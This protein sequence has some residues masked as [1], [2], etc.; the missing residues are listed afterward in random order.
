MCF[1]ITRNSYYTAP[2]PPV[3]FTAPTNV[4]GL[5]VTNIPIGPPNVVARVIA[6]TEA[7]Q[8]G[9]PGAYFK[10]LPTDVVD[11]INNVPTPR[12]PW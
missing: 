9:V 1:F 11:I 8:N 2:S 7:G 4:T 3:T 5:A 10:Y 12:M 6:F